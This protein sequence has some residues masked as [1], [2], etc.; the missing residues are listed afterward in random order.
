MLRE[1]QTDR[2][3]ETERDRDTDRQ[4]QT[5]T[6]KIGMQETS[7]TLKERE[8]ERERERENWYRGQG[9]AHG[10][11]SIRRN[12]S[13]EAAGGSVKGPTAADCKSVR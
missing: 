2:D 12:E 9:R 3:R 1:R 8:R 4:T 11:R 13:G 7:N 5:D 6:E 10:T